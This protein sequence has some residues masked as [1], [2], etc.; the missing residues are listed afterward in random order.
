MKQLICLVLLAS[1][2]AYAAVPSID[3][4]DINGVVM[5]DKGLE[6]GVWVIAEGN[7]FRTRYAKIVVT[8]ERGLLAAL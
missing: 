4:N 8:D 7:A 3:A 2:L 5:G 1:C 6:A